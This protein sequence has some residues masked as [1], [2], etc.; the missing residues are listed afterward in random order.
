MYP[1]RFEYHAPLTTE[2]A[3]SLVRDL[4]D[5]GRILAGGQSLIPMM[6]LR[7]AYPKHLID[8]NRI[9]DLA[10]VKDHD[11]VIEIG[12]ITRE[13]EIEKSPSIRK[14][15]PLLSH[16]SAQ[17]AD[18]QIRNR[19]TMVGSLCNADPSAD[20]A[21]AAIVLDAKLLA[22][23][24]G[25]SRVIHAM[26]FFEDV[27]TTSLR[28]DEIVTEVQIPFAKTNS[29]MSF[30]KL[31]RTFGDFAIVNVA[32]NLEFDADGR[33]SEARIA[34]GT[35]APIPQRMAKVEEILVDGKLDE[36]KVRRAATYAEEYCQAESDTR[37]SKEYKCSMSK[38][39]TK[40]ALLHSLQ[41]ARAKRLTK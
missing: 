21:P 26:E 14:W 31:C 33:C 25:K 19:G 15:A 9:S 39:T 32:A 8:I 11:G 10:Y 28:P 38:V 27:F 30:Q 35:V 5:E 41:E 40:R 18:T 4:G 22:R 3:I 36:E 12:A 16:V 6:K 17:I 29:V 24:A 2:E 7:I 23:S 37:G 13:S 1:P 34:I 20:Y